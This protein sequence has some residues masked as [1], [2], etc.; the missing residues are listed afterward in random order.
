MDKRRILVIED[1]AA[2]NRLLCK[3]LSENGYE[4]VGAQDGAD[5]LTQLRSSTWDLAM[6]D[7]MLPVLNGEL[8]LKKLREES[9]LPVIIISAKS[10]VKDRTAVLRLGADDYITKPFHLDEVLARVEAVLRRSG[11]ASQKQEE[12]LC[13]QDIS[14]NLHTGAVSVC[15]QE[16]RLG[17]KE[18]DILRVFLENPE[19]LF[20]KAN[21]Y[22]SVWG[23]PYYAEGD[24]VKVHVNHLRKELTAA[25]GSDSYIETIWGMGYRL[26]KGNPQ[27]K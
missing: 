11:S 14:M 25:C 1:D 8:V 13:F 9:S 27:K 5:G 15:G 16:L 7:L 17:A 2:I 4:A 12:C 19:K 23:E 6:L 21:L 3:M 18:R 20:S 24:T 22:E 10:D 26:K